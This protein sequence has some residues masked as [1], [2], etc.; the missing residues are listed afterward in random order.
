MDDESA[1]IELVS[2]FLIVYLLGLTDIF[3]LQQ[4]L[5]KTRQLSKRM[6]SKGFCSIIKLLSTYLTR[7]P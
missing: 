7:H 2:I 1:E 5:N 3:Q 6:T 4:N